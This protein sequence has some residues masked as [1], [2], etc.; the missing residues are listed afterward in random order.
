MTEEVRKRAN[1]IQA[2]IKK[3][4]NE[5]NSFMYCKGCTRID[6]FSQEVHEESTDGGFPFHSETK[7]Q[8]LYT[9]QTPEISVL[10]DSVI[11]RIKQEI[12]T[13]QKEFSEL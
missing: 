6:F 12:I 9:K 1:E 10:I 3:K 7:L 5:I 13:L 11:S 2:E 4:Q 8:S